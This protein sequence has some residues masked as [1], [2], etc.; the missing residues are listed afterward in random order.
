[1]GS[2]HWKESIGKLHGRMQ[3]LAIPHLRQLCPHI[4]TTVHLLGCPIFPAQVTILSEG[5]M[6]RRCLHFSS[7]RCP[8]IKHIFLVAWSGATIGNIL[9]ILRFA[10]ST[11]VRMCFH[12]C[13]ASNL[14][15]PTRTMCLSSN[16]LH[17]GMCSNW[18]CG[19]VWECLHGV[20]PQGPA[21]N[22]Q[23]ARPSTQVSMQ[24]SAA[25]HVSTL[26]RLVFLKER[27]HLNSGVRQAASVEAAQKLSAPEHTMR[28]GHTRPPKLK[29]LLSICDSWPPLHLVQLQHAD[30]GSLPYSTCAWIPTLVCCRLHC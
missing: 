17:H 12:N 16:L 7:W 14:M 19:P 29:P 5:R 28:K 3:K 15:L 2:R 20:Q 23:T 4:S 24:H 9:L 22:T 26:A 10:L 18:C 1:M 30:A 8:C 11:A 13:A 21:C 25:S 27:K 6:Q